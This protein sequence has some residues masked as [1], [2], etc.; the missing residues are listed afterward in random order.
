MKR[1]LLCAGAACLL[2]QNVKA[3]DAHFTQY[4]ASPLTLNPA[5]TGLTQCDLRVA[6]NYRTQWASVSSNPY[7][8]GTVSFDLA[9]LKDK[10]NNGDAL[11]VG[12]IVLYDKAGTGALTNTTAGVSLAYHK[13]LGIEKQHNI[14]LGVQGM[15]VQK[16]IDFSKLQF[17]DQF[18]RNTGIVTNNQTGENISNQD[19]NYPD[20]NVGLMYSGKVSDNATAYAGFSWYHL[21]QPQESF[22]NTIGGPGADIK[23]S[24]RYTGYLGGSF[25][26][27]ENTVL[28]ASGLYQQQA[29]AS[30]VV[31]GAAVG[32]VLNPGYDVDYKRGTILYLGSWWRYGDAIAP[33]IGFEWSKMQLGISY[34]VNVSSFTPATNGNG[35]YEISLIYNGCI[36]KRERGP[37]YNV[38]CPKF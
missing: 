18:D 27:N 34:D 12:I 14:S 3:Q 25:N 17:E 1:I 5:L 9:T 35:A 28:Y 10:L 36:N 13:A 37:K 6:A 16:R 38:S 21:T 4:F 2:M 7:I 20:F 29:K 30:E 32:F 31:L 26:L 15:L 33:Y 23:I 24:S 22:L 11:G 8:T 19:L